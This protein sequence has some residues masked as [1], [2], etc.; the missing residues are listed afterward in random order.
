MLKKSIFLILHSPLFY[1]LSILNVVLSALF[2]FFFNQFFIFGIGSTDIRPLFSVLPYIFSFSVPLFVSQL[3]SLINDE[4]LPVSSFYKIFCCSTALFLCSLISA[5]LLIFIPVS[6]S[7]FGDV[8]FSLFFVEFSGFSFWLF[9]T[10]FFS[11]FLFVLMSSKI[12]GSFISVFLSIV[13]LEVLNFIHKIPVYFEISSFFASILKFFSFSWHFDNFSKGIFDFSNLFFFALCAFLFLELSVFVCEKNKGMV[14]D[15]KSLFFKAAFFLLSYVCLNVFPLSKC[16][17]DLSLSKDYSFSKESADFFKGIDKKVKITY[18]CSEQLS[19]FYPQTQ[20]ITDYLESFSSLNSKFSFSRTII[21][22]KSEEKIRSFNLKGQPLQ[23]IKKNRMENVFVY[24]AVLIEVE[25][26]SSLVPFIL[27]SENLEFELLRRLQ[28]LIYDVKRNVIVVSGGETSVEE[29]YSYVEPWLKSRLFNVQVMSAKDFSDFMDLIN[30]RFDNGTALVLLGSSCL[31]EK[32]VSS[33]EKARS[34]GMKILAFVSPFDVDVFG[35]WDIGESSGSYKNDEFLKYLDQ[36]GL[37]LEPSLVSDISC[38]PLFLEE[39]SENDSLSKSGTTINFPLWISVLSQAN[40]EGGVTLS[41]PS[42]ISFFGGS[43]PL[44]FTSSLAWKND[45]SKISDISAFANPFTTFKTSKEAGVEPEKIAVAGASKDSSIKVVS[46]KYFLSS[47]MTGF[48]SG[49]MSENVQ[50]DF[51]NF[52]WTCIELYKSFGD[53]QI[54]SLMTKKRINKSFY[55]VLSDSYM[56]DLKSRSIF[57]SFVVPVLIIA[58]I[59]IFAAFK[60]KKFNEN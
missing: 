34:L 30:S 39:N 6:S 28:N 46:D 15:R 56:A 51:R 60:R 47:I 42:P 3:V 1:A 2:F 31:S 29:D 41:W 35:G 50:G 22:E 33:I 32:Q 55:K 19:D 52:D 45:F 23:V 11:V 27:S 10:V 38:V 18:F 21:D 44:F 58:G 12:S 9:A 13:F 40:C 16:K 24:S 43:Y 37:V 20:T 14:F 57:L 36:Q 4:S 8:D 49:A 53:S 25:G 7:F 17:V 59:Y 54:V 48:K 5:C 26:E